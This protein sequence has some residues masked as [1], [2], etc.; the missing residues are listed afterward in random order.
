M[1]LG[2]DHW[3]NELPDLELYD[4]DVD[5]VDLMSAGAFRRYPY[6]RY[7]NRYLLRVLNEN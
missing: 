1:W 2:K 4:V 5:A 7:N 3:Q 6:H